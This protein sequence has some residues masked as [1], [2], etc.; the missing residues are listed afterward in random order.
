[1][2]TIS[3]VN[4]KGGV[5]KSTSAINTAATLAAELGK[6]VLLID[7]DSQGNA[8]KSLLPPG[9]YNTLELV[10]KGEEPYYENLIY[11]S[12]VRNLDVLPGDISLMDAD[13][14]SLTSGR[15]NLN[16]IRDLRDALTEDDAYDYMVIDCPPSFSAAC[17][18]AIAASEHIVIPI[19]LDMFSFYGMRELTAQ[20]DGVR[21]L[22][23]EVR[24]AG[25]LVTMWY[26]EEAVLQGEAL[27]RREAL[28]PVFDTVIRRTPKVDE[29]TWA[30]EPVLTYSP[31]SAAAQDY[32]KFVA[33]FLA[34]EEARAYGL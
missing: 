18:A 17:A 25:C 33:E 4:L 2:K 22:H 13:L 1:M 23:P 26:R 31:R 7:A 19:K 20:I 9:E 10:L 14:A 6:R 5:G 34:R 32:R 29:S 11:P 27:L 3:F 28:V 12:M 8:S 30:R 15:V 16:A 21:R 24:I